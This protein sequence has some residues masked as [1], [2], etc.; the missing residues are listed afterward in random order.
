MNFITDG[1]SS[2]NYLK[3]IE[4]DS[5]TAEYIDRTLPSP[6][7]SKD[8]LK[9]TATAFIGTI[10]P[11]LKRILLLNSR[12]L[13]SMGNTLTSAKVNQEISITSDLV[14]DQNRDQ[15][16]AYIVQVQDDNGVTISLKHT[17]G[18]VPPNRL[19]VQ[20]CDGFPPLREFIQFKFLYGEA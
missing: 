18:T 6:Y 2:G 17:S 14:N 13:D 3:V 1:K 20:C 15:P 9:L 4:G 8:Q 11:P 12:L 16:Y 10:T 5:V 7:T 19:I